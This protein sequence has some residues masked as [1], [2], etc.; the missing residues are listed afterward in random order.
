MIREMERSDIPAC[1]DVIRAAFATVADEFGI[2]AENAPRFTAFATDKMRIEWH[3]LHEKRPMFVYMMDG[4]IVGY[5]SLMMMENN[6][7]ELNNLCVLPA[8]RHNGIGAQL[9]QHAF[10]YAKVQNCKVMNIGIV[11]E[12]QVLRKWYESFG[13]VHTGTKKVDFFPFTCGYLVRQV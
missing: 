7:C 5:Y 4:Q 1:V 10:Q 9:L 6:A 11:E 12:N 2:T 13:F 3:F 8:Y